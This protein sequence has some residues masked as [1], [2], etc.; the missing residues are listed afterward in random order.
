MKI[1]FIDYFSF[2]KFIIKLWQF[3]GT[4]PKMGGIFIFFYVI[5]KMQ[6]NQNM[7]FRS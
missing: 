3:Y 1:Q 6:M 2:Q 4:F 5:K 7:W